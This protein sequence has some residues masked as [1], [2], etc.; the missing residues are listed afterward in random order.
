MHADTCPKKPIFILN[1]WSKEHYFKDWMVYGSHWYHERTQCC[2]R[3]KKR[4]YFCKYWQRSFA[5]AFA[6]SYIDING[7]IFLS[8]TVAIQQYIG[9]M[10]GLCPKSTLDN[11]LSM[12][13]LENC[14]DIMSESYVLQYIHALYLIYI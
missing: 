4:R 10:T 11:S 5:T 9:Q 6:R 2:K 14:N 12:M 8:Q 3:W 1:E 7:Q 13:I